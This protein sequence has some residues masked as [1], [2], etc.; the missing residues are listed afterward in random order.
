MVGWPGR[1]RL[2][3]RMTDGSGYVIEL[4]G[5]AAGL[6]VKEGDQFRFYS[7]ATPFSELEQKLYRSPGEA[8]GACRRLAG[9]TRRSRAKTGGQGDGADPGYIATP[10]T[11]RARRTRR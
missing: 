11:L 7:A 5:E 2:E 8:E 6:V 10:T 1:V 3:R 4:A 9:A